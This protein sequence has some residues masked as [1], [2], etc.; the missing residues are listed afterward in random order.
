M[1]WKLEHC[2]YFD[3]TIF[4]K[5]FWCTCYYCQNSDSSKVSIKR[6]ISLRY[7]FLVLINSAIFYF[8]YM[9]IGTISKI[10]GWYGIRYSYDS[11]SVSL[12][13]YQWIN[14]YHHN[15]IVYRNN[16]MHKLPSYDFSHNFGNPYCH[17]YFHLLLTRRIATKTANAP[18]LWMSA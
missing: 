17:L 14:I 6:S 5:M 9:N 12:S 4:R 7:R 3:I 11:F 8:N 13:W 15:D 10:H 18:G 1:Q 2:Y 16:L